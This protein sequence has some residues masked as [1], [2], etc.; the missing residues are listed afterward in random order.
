MVG[1]GK[2][3]PENHV[4]RKRRQ[5]ELP[6]FA[7]IGQNGYATLPRT[8]ITPATTS[9]IAKMKVTPIMTT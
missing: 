3:V 7:F 6:P 8:Y 5:Q 2:K 9:R 1:L 4:K